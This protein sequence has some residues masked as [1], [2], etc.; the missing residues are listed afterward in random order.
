MTLL[1]NPLRVLHDVLASAT[2]PPPP[3]DY[4]AWAKQKE[5]IYFTEEQSQFPGPY[6]ET[7]FPLFTEIFKALSPEEACRFVSLIKSAQTGGTI[8][9]NIFTLGTMDL[10]PCLFLYVHPTEENGDRWSKQK[11]TPMIRTSKRMSQLFPERTKDSSNSVRYKEREDGRG[12]IQVA[13]ANSAANLSQMTCAKQVHDDLAKWEDNSGGDP[14]AQAESRSKAITQAK[15]FKISTP[16]VMPGCRITRA[17]EEGSQER[18]H[19]PCPHCGGFQS[20]EWENMRDHIDIDHP[21][22]AHFKCIHCPGK[23]EEKHRDWMIDPANG[24][25][26]VAKY[27][28]RKNW[29][30]SFYIWMAYSKLE[31]WSTIAREWAKVQRAANEDGDKANA[32]SLEQTFYNDSLGLPL[33]V[34][35]SAVDWEVLRDRAEENERKKSIVPARALVLILGIDVQ[36]SWVEWTLWGYGAKAYRAVIDH[37]TFDGREGRRGEGE[38]EHTGHISE[39]E[40]RAALDKLIAR[41][42]IDENNILRNIEMTG[43][44]GNYSTADVFTWARKHPRSRVIMVRGG[45]SHHA[46]PLLQVQYET[47]KRGKKKVRPYAS[48]FFTFNSSEFKLRLMRHLR[49]VDPEQPGYIDLPAGMGDIFWQGLTSET[50][51]MKNTAGRTSWKWE[52]LTGRRNEVLDNANQAHA[53]AYRL[54]LPYYSED[55]WQARADELAQRAPIVPDLEDMM[56]MQP[57]GERPQTKTVNKTTDAAAAL[58]RSRAARRG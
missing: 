46:P 15:I 26:W 41:Q 31:S 58:A 49:K 18:Y 30:R 39:P 33:V 44:D 24:A 9:A 1:S 56:M 34:D 5:N 29:H 10:A 52:V 19:V 37:G 7:N 57:S 12:A 2:A 40:I 21:E 54:G 32:R 6:D 13:G 48:R 8:G 51:V 35:Q 53:A 43:V 36:E 38:E 14:E 16:L 25:H 3:V 27:P 4:L 47:D 22:A 23:I 28:E 55:D 45:N 11:L 42:W 20:L 50:R 17:Y